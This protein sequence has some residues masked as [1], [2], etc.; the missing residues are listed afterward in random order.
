MGEYGPDSSRC[1]FPQIST[2]LYEYKKK[3]T[4]TSLTRRIQSTD[5]DWPFPEICFKN[6]GL[7]VR[8]FNF[9]HTNLSISR[10]SFFQPSENLLNIESRTEEA[11]TLPTQYSFH[12]VQQ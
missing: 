12:P 3:K 4:A 10:K 1:E 6:I 8:G 2:R 11:S 7:T 9:F 5:S